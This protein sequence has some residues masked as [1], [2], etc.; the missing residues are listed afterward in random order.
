ME[1]EKN[2]H[3]ALDK[4]S[5][6]QQFRKSDVIT[7]VVWKIWSHTPSATG[8]YGRQAGRQTKYRQISIFLKFVLE[9][10][11]STLLGLTKVIDLLQQYKCIKVGFSS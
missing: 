11:I 3:G 4:P 6:E 1:D 8:S 5:S 10:N 9:W 7:F 2:H